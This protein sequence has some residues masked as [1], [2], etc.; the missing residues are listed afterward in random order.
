MQLDEHDVITGSVI[1]SIVTRAFILIARARTPILRLRG[2]G[3]SLC[4]RLTGEFR[5]SSVVSRVWRLAKSFSNPEGASY[6]QSEHGQE[7]VYQIVR[8]QNSA[9]D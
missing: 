3:A 6:L 8:V 4:R 1:N 9:T 5:L 2:S 7:V